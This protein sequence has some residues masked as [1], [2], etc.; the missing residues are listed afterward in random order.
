MPA[1]ERQAITCAAWLMVQSA[2]LG[3]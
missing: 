1:D 2:S 3:I